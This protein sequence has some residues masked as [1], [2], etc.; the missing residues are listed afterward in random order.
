MI[1]RV[2]FRY[3]QGS[4][5]IDV[6]LVEGKPSTAHRVTTPTSKGEEMSGGELEIFWKSQA[7]MSD[8]DFGVKRIDSVSTIEFAKV[9]SM[10]TSIKRQENLK[11]SNS[12]KVSF[13]LF[14]FNK[15]AK[16]LKGVAKNQVV[17][18]SGEWF[19]RIGLCLKA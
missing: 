19:R 14:A 15:I 10:L 8:D 13:K 7:T 17:V 1:V 2:C 6:Y 11:A 4:E 3:P 12:V 5:E 9:N 18:V 16:F